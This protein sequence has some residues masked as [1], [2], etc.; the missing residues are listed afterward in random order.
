VPN[1]TR[2][3]SISLLDCACATPNRPA[4]R[5][6]VPTIPDH[7]NPQTDDLD[8]PIFFQVTGTGG[9]LTGGPSRNSGRGV[10]RPSQ[11][12]VTATGGPLRGSRR[13]LSGFASDAVGYGHRIAKLVRSGLLRLLDEL[14]LPLSAAARR[15]PSDSLHQ[16]WT[17]LDARAR[18]PAMARGT[19]Q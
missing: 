15:P 4:G 7:P 1:D 13:R 10:Q 5:R 11:R 9:R 16:E 6:P 14:P 17:N 12:G 8:H 2:T 19:G 3:P 18:G